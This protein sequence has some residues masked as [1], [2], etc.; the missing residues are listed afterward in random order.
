M[1]KDAYYFPHFSNA[2][3]DRKLRRIQMEL[4]VEGYGIYFMILE[5]LREQPEFRYPI[6][7]ID[8]LAD[9][10]RTSEQKV[11]VV[12]K[13]YDLFQVDE[14]DMFFSPRFDEYLQPYLEAK[15][16]RKIG[17]IKGNL[18]KHNHISK[19]QAKEMTDAEILAFN[20]N[21]RLSLATDSLPTRSASQ[22]KVKESK[23]KESKEEKEPT[24]AP[25]K[26]I[27]DLYNSIC[28]SLPSARKLSDH[29]RKHIKARWKEEKDLSVFEKCFKKAEASDFMSG[30]NNRDWKANLDWIIK[31]N[32]NFN[33]VLEGRYDNEESREDSGNGK[34]EEKYNDIPE[35]M[36]A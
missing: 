13:K 29:R 32:T 21:L 36:L 35:H 20:E 18:I 33:K 2:R 23:G 5:V 22:S 30:D 19:E 16:R 14:D 12:V 7:D 10:F 25:I 26:E 28:E 4:G 6:Q 27:F 11:E 31:N 34:Q 3:Q 8:L 1:R 9:E 17:G 15:E 24:P